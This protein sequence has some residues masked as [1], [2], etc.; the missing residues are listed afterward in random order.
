M[1]EFLSVKRKMLLYYVLHFVS[2]GDMNYLY[3]EN[4]VNKVK[5]DSNLSIYQ[6]ICHGVLKKY[7]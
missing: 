4:E 2:L 5:Y 6:L 7:L 1:E 3:F